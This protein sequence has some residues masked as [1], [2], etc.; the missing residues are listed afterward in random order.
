MDED[1]RG[2]IEQLLCWRGLVVQ[3]SQHRQCCCAESLCDGPS[4]DFKPM[5]PE[6]G[7]R[8]CDG[9]RRC[10]AWEHTAE[11]EVVVVVVM[12]VSNVQGGRA[13]DGGWPKETPQSR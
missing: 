12:V 1:G 7:R 4:S 5:V 13:C 9:R 10:G 2:R 11:E 6:L 8:I 3:G